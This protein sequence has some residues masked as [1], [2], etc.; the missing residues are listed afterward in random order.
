M[1][2]EELVE[3]IKKNFTNED[4]IIDI[5]E[6]DFE[7]DHVNISHLKT[8]GDL[9]QYSQEGGGTLWQSFQKVGGNLLQ[10]SQKVQR[11]LYQDQQKVGKNLHQGDQQVGGNLFQESQKANFYF[12]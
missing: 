8:S 6:M 5:S 7:N 3:L 12:F 11:N 9:F 4:G 1:T 10:Y 2:K